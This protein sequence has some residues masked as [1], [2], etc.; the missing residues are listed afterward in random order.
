MELFCVISLGVC[1]CQALLTESNIL[2]Q[3]KVLYSG[4]P[5][6]CLQIY[7]KAV[8]S[9]N[10]I[11][12]SVFDKRA[13]MLAFLLLGSEITIVTLGLKFDWLKKFTTRQKEKNEAM[14]FG[15]FEATII[16]N[17]IIQSSRPL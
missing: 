3:G 17:K 7:S 15:G 10:Y 5:Q 1:H 12:S 11:R 16:R 9:A 4:K 14:H 6:R 8:V 2:E 13:I